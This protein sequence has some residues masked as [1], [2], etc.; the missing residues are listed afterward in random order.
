MDALYTKLFIVFVILKNNCINYESEINIKSLLK[1]TLFKFLTDV[2]I[3]KY[4][5]K[6][7][8]SEYAKCVYS[9][10]STKNI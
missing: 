4:S 10:L 9:E 1:L 7:I 3:Q 8:K 5:L 6:L 2:I